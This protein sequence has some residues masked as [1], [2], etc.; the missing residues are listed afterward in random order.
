MNDYYQRNAQRV[1]ETASKSRNRRLEAVREYDR[2]RGIGKIRDP[3]KEA[4]RRK[5][6]VLINQLGGRPPCE[7]CGALSA[8][9]HHKDYSRPLDVVWLC[10]KHHMELHRRVA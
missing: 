5:V 8:E 7:V 10:R 4:A 6:R 9:A 2:M 3:E 1:R